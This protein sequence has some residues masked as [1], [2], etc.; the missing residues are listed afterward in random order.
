MSPLVVFVFR[1]SSVPFMMMK[2]RP[3]PTPNLR[4]QYSTECR[5]NHYVYTPFHLPTM[6]IVVSTETSC[7]KREEL[8]TMMHDMHCSEDDGCVDVAARS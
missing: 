6:I 1:H 7:S 3:L 8:S 2:Q 5:Q 4:L